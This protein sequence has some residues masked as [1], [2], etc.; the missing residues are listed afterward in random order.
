M[1]LSYNWLK[2][3]VDIKLSP[4][5]LAEKLNLSGLPVEE[6]TET[7][8]GVT[9]VV[10][11]RILKIEKHP[12]ADKLSYCD[13]SDGTNTYKV[14][15]G[16]QNITEGMTVP[17]ATIGAVL[18]GDFKIKRSKIRGIESEGMLC[19]AKELGIGG[20][21]SGILPLDPERFPVGAS[22]SPGVPDTLL[23]IEITPN[24]PDLLSMIGAARFIAAI[25]GAKVNEP[26]CSIKPGLIDNSTDINKMLSVDVTD[27][28]LCP[29]YCA[30]VIKNVK[31]TESPDWLKKK[32][33]NLGVRPINNIVDITNY[34][35]FELN[36]PLHAFDYKKIR[37]AKI[38]VRTAADGETITALDGKVYK[39]KSTDLMIADESSP[40]AIAGVMGGEHFSVTPETTD[41]VLESAFFNPGTVRKT[42]R[43]LG[44][45]SD[46][47]Y[48]FERG[49]DIQ[50]T[51]NAMNRAA[52]MMAEI[53][54]GMVSGNFI[55]V[56]PN[57]RKL[58]SITLRLQRVNKLLGT[59]FSAAEV[60]GILDSA[61]FKNSESGGVFSITVPGYRVDLAEEI[62]LIEEIAQTAGYDR[63][64]STL[65]SAAITLGSEPPAETFSKKLSDIFISYGFSQAY[66]YSF[67]NTKLLKALGASGY[68]PQNPALL[69]NPFNE[70][71]SAM[72]TTL[73]PDLIKNLIHNVN[74][75]EHNVHLFETANLFSMPE[76]GRYEQY[77]AIGCIT[78]GAILPAAFSKKELITD[79]YFLKSVINSLISASD[80]SS[81]PEYKAASP[82]PLFLEYGFEII[83]K[84]RVI[85]CGGQIKEEILHD[86][87]MKEK[88]FACEIN[89]NELL[90]ISTGTV[91]YSGLSP[92]PAVKRDLSLLL[93]SSV[94]A[95]SVENTIRSA[96]PR[97][98]NSITLFDMYKGKQV[99]D[100]KKSLSYNI[101][102]RSKER[103][104]SEAEINKTMENILLRLKENLKAELR[105]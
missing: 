80:A 2:E 83:V 33:A 67:L 18:P 16:A 36:Q 39:A 35:L 21:H 1:I 42:A 23:S 63:I 38:V 44:I 72:K 17:L 61:N 65:P 62:D 14:V 25:T 5:E 102:F 4:T 12:N 30:R 27:A 56:Y 103:T 87:K 105:S 78:Y 43:S 28:S 50:N 47:S 24:R 69:K 84:G 41:I 98:I 81:A 34:V 57:P 59:S 54:G 48:R 49:I 77:P 97:L 8:A 55:D 22:Y 26:D 73:I 60:S 58:N 76:A 31:V 86:N 66:N 10:V 68:K 11:A 100:G 95:A 64:P 51:V 104:L 20:D 75:E 3:L 71:E 101:V 53:S 13:V 91:K 89:L 52:A 94:P 70:E 6:I 88:A 15:C 96:N 29:R 9:G 32:L 99:P 40:I 74:N 37:G 90:S 79:L 46:S 82:Y 7:G 85:G 19:S 45:S 92:Y 93:D